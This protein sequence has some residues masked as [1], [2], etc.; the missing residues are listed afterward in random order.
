MAVA[1]QNLTVYRGYSVGVSKITKDYLGQLIP[2]GAGKV[3]S[4]RIS[5]FITETQFIDENM[6]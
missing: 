5:L 3:S 4:L 6:S 1:R 2:V